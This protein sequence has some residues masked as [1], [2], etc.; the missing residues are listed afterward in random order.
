MVGI[1][2]CGFDYPWFSTEKER[3]LVRDYFSE[4]EFS[5]LAG[6]GVKMYEWESQMS[7][8]LKR[9]SGRP[10]KNYRHE[11]I[12]WNFFWSRDRERYRTGTNVFY[13]GDYLY[14]YGHHFIL[15]MRLK[16]GKYLINAD[17]YSSSTST[18][19]MCIHTAPEGT[20]QIPFS[21]LEAA[22]FSDYQRFSKRDIALLDKDDDRWEEY[23]DPKTGEERQ[24][25]H[26]GSSLFRAVDQR[27]GEYEY[28]LSGLEYQRGRGRES[29]YLV[30]LFMPAFTI[31]SALFQISGLSHRDYE[32]Y[33]RGEILRQGEYFFAPE[34]TTEE[35]KR[36][37]RI[38]NLH[39]RLEKGVNIGNVLF[40]GSAPSRNAHR[41]TDF[42][43]LVAGLTYL[44]RGT[45]RH[46]EHGIMNLGKRWHTVS[47]NFVR[48]SWSARGRVD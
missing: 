10:I 35:V 41:V 30:Q 11:S 44:V 29:Y 36:K 7:E 39:E 38:K 5:A 15:A 13:E 1:L 32:R 3:E 22:G 4:E 6:M 40:R 33:E 8:L 16:N 25:H 45:V 48:D 37:Y 47:L 19:T 42:I 23:I 18:H 9:S 31:A 46:P 28:F 26:L 20:P 27:T 14:S 2:A 43:K 12:I 34:G 24:Q 17:T 21:A